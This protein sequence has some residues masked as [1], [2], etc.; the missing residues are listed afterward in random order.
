MAALEQIGRA[1]FN[2]E[3][4]VYR[5]FFKESEVGHHLLEGISRC[6]APGWFMLR[7][8][9]SIEKFSVFNEAY[10]E[11][12]AIRGGSLD[13]PATRRILIPRGLINKTVHEESSNE[14]T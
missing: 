8:G 3:N 2:E 4:S 7:P 6:V 11:C 12:L 1:L 13:R 10:E 5:I 9:Y 14:V